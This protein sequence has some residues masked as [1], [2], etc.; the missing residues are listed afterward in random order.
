MH[1]FFLILAGLFEVGFTSSLVKADQTT[2]WVSYSW[3][4]GFLLSLS[5]SMLFLILAA[6]EIP[7]GTAYAV[8]AG[9]GAVGTVLMGVFVFNEGVSFWRIFFIVTL[10][11]SIVGLKLKG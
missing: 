11:S 8:F 3:Y 5:L 2:G 7:M 4:G 10:I 1:W 6:K 9:V